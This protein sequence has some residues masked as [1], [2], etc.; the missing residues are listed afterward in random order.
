MQVEWGELMA[1]LKHSE[2]FKLV[3]NREVIE[4]KIDVPKG[5]RGS[6]CVFYAM[7]VL[8]GSVFVYVLINNGNVKKTFL[9]FIQ[10]SAYY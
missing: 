9:M 7:A 3:A 1:W 6:N 2:S 8:W 5:K 10:S 4:R